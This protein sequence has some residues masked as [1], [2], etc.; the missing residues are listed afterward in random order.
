[1]FN[2]FMDDASNILKFEGVGNF[3]SDVKYVTEF[4]VFKPESTS[5]QVNINFNI[6]INIIFQFS[7]SSY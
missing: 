6:Q 3:S 5:K 2:A 1:M 7:L 4:W